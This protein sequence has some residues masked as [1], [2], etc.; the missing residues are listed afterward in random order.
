M[1]KTKRKYGGTTDVS[2]GTIY[3]PPNIPRMIHTEIRDHYQLNGYESDGQYYRLNENYRKRTENARNKIP[4]GSK[5]SDLQFKYAYK[6]NTRSLDNIL[7]NRQPPVQF[8]HV[9]DDIQLNHNQPFVDLDTF[10]TAP[11]T[12]P[13]VL[14]SP[15]TP[16]SASVVE[17][18]VNKVDK[19]GRTALHYAVLGNHLSTVRYLLDNSAEFKKDKDGFYPIDYAKSNEVYMFLKHRGAKNSWNET[20]RHAN[21]AAGGYGSSR[22]V[23][24]IK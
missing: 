4:K 24:R 23:K 12:Q 17:E 5:D 22:K 13:T 18:K 21:I 6:G 7:Y 8:P 20:K 19:M 3:I 14:P 1:R 15:L 10:L 9:T 11:A 16:P 2:P